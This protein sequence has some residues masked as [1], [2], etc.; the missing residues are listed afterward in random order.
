[1]AS[2]GID[3]I[4]EMAQDGRTDEALAELDRVLGEV[5]D[6]PRLHVL[7]AFLLLESGRL[8]EAQR[9]A[10]LA[11]ALDDED[12]LPLLALARV[13]LAAGEP[14]EAIACARAAHALVPEDHEPVVI[15]ARARALLGQWDEVIARAEYVLAEDPHDVE[16]AFLR[17]AA[18]ESRAKGA[19][20]IDAAEWD[21]LA[22]RFPHIATAR[23]GRAWTL[24]HRGRPRQ[25]EHEFRDAL[26]LDPA[27]PWAKEGLVLALKA[28]YPGY[29]L[30]LRFFFWLQSLPPGTQTAVLIGGVVGTRMLRGLARAEP[31]LA[32]FVTPVIALYF[33]FV[34]LTWLADPLLDLVLL[35]RPE[36]RRLIVGD[37]RRRAVAV[38]ATLGVGLLIAAAGLLSSSDV[39]LGAAVAVG[40]TSLTTAAGFACAPGRQRAGLLIASGT[41]A[42]LGIVSMMVTVDTGALLL[43]IAVIGVVIGTWVSRSLIRRS[44]EGHR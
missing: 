21:R 18:L 3:D 37:T 39:A 32:P 5:N 15:E 29:T 7:R 26:A 34:L 19:A 20:R 16:A 36:G 11:H 1:M 10:E 31:L 13:A 22:E 44:H 2:Q 24:L 30:L 12:H 4:I 40:L 14:T 17:I 35:T 43:G 8:A 28:R 33:A 41:F 42:A 27:D 6:E 38:G 9:A 23:A 25:A